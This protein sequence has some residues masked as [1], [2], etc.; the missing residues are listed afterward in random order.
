MRRRYSMIR[1]HTI[2]KHIPIFISELLYL[3]QV[4]ININNYKWKG[5]SLNTFVFTKV[6]L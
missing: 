5:Y 1:N 4:K 6:I 2:N 3:Y